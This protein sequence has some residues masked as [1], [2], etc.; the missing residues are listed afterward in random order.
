[1]EREDIKRQLGNTEV[2]IGQEADP[3]LDREALGSE[4]TELQGLASWVRKGLSL[5]LR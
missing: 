2:K 4:L 5:L 3:D 1:M